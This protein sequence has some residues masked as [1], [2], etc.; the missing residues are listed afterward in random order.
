MEGRAIARPNVGEVVRVPAG[1][2]LLQ[3]RAGQLPGRTCQSGELGRFTA[4]VLQWRAGQLPGRTVRDTTVL[5][6]GWMPSM[7]GRAIARPNPGGVVEDAVTGGVPSMEG[8]AIARPNVNEPEAEAVLVDCLQWRAGQLPGRTARRAVLMDFL[9]SPS[10][11][12][13]AIARP[14]AEPPLSRRLRDPTFNGG[15]GNCPA[16]P[17]A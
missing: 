3:W 13:R 14:N 12:G 11:E 4:S 2:D 7:E 17:L 5:W 15:P 1:H 16:E 8:R 9:D 6:S 10:M